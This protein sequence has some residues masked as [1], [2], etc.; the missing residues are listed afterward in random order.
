MDKTV[1]DRIKKNIRSIRKLNTQVI[2]SRLHDEYD[3][4][5]DELRNWLGPQAPAL[6]SPVHMI[7]VFTD[8]APL[9]RKVSERTGKSSIILGLNHGQDFNRLQDRRL[10]MYLLAVV[11]PKHVWFSFPCGCWGPWSRFNIAKGGKSESTVLQQRKEARR[12]LR[13]VSEAWQLQRLLGGHCHAENPLTSEAWSEIFVG[14]VFDVRIDMCSVGMRCPKTNV[15]VLKPTRIIT[16]MKELADRLTSCRCDHKHGHAHLEGKLKGRNL[17]SW[18]EVYPNKMCRII[19]EVMS[20]VNIDPCMSHVVLFDEDDD[21]EMEQQQPDEMVPYQEGEPQPLAVSQKIKAIVQKLHVNTGHASPEQMLRLAKRCKSSADMQT[22]IKQFK[23]SVCEELKVPQ[24]RR[25]ATMPHAENPNDIVGMDYV[26]VELKREDNQGVMREIKH[27][28]LTCV[29]LATGFA[30][31]IICPTGHSMAEAFH[32][33]W[34]RPYGLPN[35][36][37]M[38]PAMANVSKEFQNY[39]AQNDIK[40]LLAAAESHWQLGLVEVTNRV[41][42]HM[43]QRVWRTTSRPAKEVIETCATTR[44]EQLRRC[45]FSPSQWFLGKD[46]RQ[47]GMLRDLDEQHNIA[48][49]S[50]II[51]SPDFYEKVRLRE[52]AAIAFHEE[53][54]KDIWRRAI[55]GRSRPIRGPYQVGQLVYVFRR[56]ARGLLSTRHGVWIGPGKVVGTESESGGPTPRVVWVSYNGYLYRCSPEGLRPVP[57]D[58]AEFRSLARSL[59]EGRLHPE[60]ENAEQSVSSRSGQFA[61][62]T[63]EHEPMDEDH[64]LEEDLWEEP[65]DPERELDEGAPRKIRRRITRSP[66][67]W[68]HRAEG[69]P[70]LGPLHADAEMPTVIR[71]KPSRPG[72]PIDNEPDPKRKVQINSEAEE[73]EYEPSIASE[74]PETGDPAVQ[75][76]QTSHADPSVAAQE[77]PADPSTDGADAMKQPDP[78]PEE[79]P[80][81]ITTPVPNNRSDDELLLE[82]EDA[83]P[84]PDKHEVM[85]VSIE[86]RP[87]DIAENPLFLWGVIEDCFNVVPKAKQRKVEV[88]Y[89]KL[90]VEDK[91]KFEVAMKKEWQSWIDNKV[92]SLCHSRGIPRERIIRA[93]WVLVWKKSSDPGNPSQTPKARLVLVGWQDPEL[94]R[95]KT[96]SP[97]LRKESKNLILS[98]CAAKK[99]KIWG[100]DIKTAF[101]SGDPSDRQLYFR[102]P[103]EIKSWMKLDRDQLFRL[104]KAAYGLAEAPRAWFLRLSRELSE[105]GLQV[106]Q[107]DRCL[108]TLRNKK[109]ELIGICGVHVNDL[110][111]G[112]TPEMD[113]VLDS[114]KKKL[115]IGDY[116]TFTIR[117][118]GIEIRQNPHTYEIEIGQEAYIDSLQPISTKSLGSAGTPIRDV[119]LLRQCAGQ[120]AWAAGSTRPDQAFLASYL[121]GVQDKGTVSHITTFNKALREM[122]ERRITIKFPSNVPI[123]QW[124]IICIGDAGHAKRANGDSQRGYPLGLTNPSMRD[125]KQAPMWLVDW[126][127]NAMDA[128]EFF[129]ALLAETIH[130]ITPKQFRLQV[131]KHTALLVVDSRGF[132]DAASKLSSASTSEE[133]KLEIDYAIARQAMKLQNIEIYWINNNYMAADCLTKLNGETRLLF[134]LLETGVYQIKRCQESGSKERA[135]N[136]QEQK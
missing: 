12:H 51:E 4:V 18:C 73:L 14:E 38:D 130:G 74:A 107:L 28:V 66:E 112:V 116:R 10:L 101:L 120:L 127:I 27:N 110:L 64:E 41:L 58:E 20:E 45:G 49:A 88:N 57:E 39:L 92:T 109:G 16:T 81:P 124:R 15:P 54:A 55:G 121:Q 48:T 77:S 95:I 35:T 133:K 123:D 99:W 43:A 128:I 22:A 62:L 91:A 115:P 17:S 46:G 5:L 136:R 82:H 44:N 11:R 114:L 86:V 105:Q 79:E 125:R 53:H 65:N 71:L 94:G 3:Q 50:Q 1:G 132:Y 131:P 42:R 134:V 67:Y 118:T 104:E 13:A 78:P 6:D 106:S 36:I 135:R 68:E 96:D 70:P 26:Q 30:Q 24:S 108:F 2:L 7:E 29:C 122:K 19:A 59:A 84:V 87:D 111:G 117:Y 52:Q 47:V 32:D 69:A 100:A 75:S 56:R 34:A 129:Q 23:C 25:Q 83:F 90:S 93:R 76:E 60:L 61:D 80:N 98:I 97:T 63:K 85:E 37:Y 33:V 8:H 126:G 103:E 119:S 40:L 21:E 9:A 102:P 113:R 31:Q 72:P 89:R